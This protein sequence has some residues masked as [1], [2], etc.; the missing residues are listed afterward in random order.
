MLAVRLPPLPDRLAVC[1][2][3]PSSVEY[4]TVT[5]LTLDAVAPF[6]RATV[7][8]NGNVVFAGAR[9]KLSNDPVDRI[10]NSGN[11]TGSAPS[12]CDDVKV[13]LAETRV[14]NAD[15]CGLRL[16]VTDRVYLPVPAGMPKKSRM[17]GW[18]LLARV[19]PL[20]DRVVW[21]VT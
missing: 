3:L 12:T 13:Q 10:T 19:A 11:G 16:A 7:T 20:P 18:A 15:Q 9:S 1:H 5:D 21:P 14:D 4:F 8:V 17:P 2:V 6:C